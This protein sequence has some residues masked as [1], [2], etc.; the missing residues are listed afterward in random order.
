M[1]HFIYHFTDD[2]WVLIG[3]FDATRRER[4]KKLTPVDRDTLLSHKLI[5]IPLVGFQ[6]TNESTL[7]KDLLVLLVHHDLSDLRSLILIQFIPNGR[8][9]CISSRHGKLFVKHLLATN[10]IRIFLG[11]SKLRKN[12]SGSLHV[13]TGQGCALIKKLDMFFSYQLL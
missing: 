6:A 7:G 10:S 8:N 2:I 4:I 9:H 12:L 13:I 1:K 3:V 5:L 11:R